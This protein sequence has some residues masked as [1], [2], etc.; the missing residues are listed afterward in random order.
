MAKFYGISKIRAQNGSAIGRVDIYGEIDSMQ[1]WGDEVTPAGFL[2]DLNALGPVSGIDVHIF[3][4]GGFGVS[5]VSAS[6]TP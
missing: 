4:N 2:A 6:K 5:E 1:F 3:S